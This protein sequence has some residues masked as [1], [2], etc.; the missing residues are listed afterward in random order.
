MSKRK[1][2]HDLITQQEAEA[3]THST[4][5]REEND[6]DEIVEEQCHVTFIDF[7]DGLKAF[8]MEAKLCYG[9]Y[10]KLSPCNVASICFLI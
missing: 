8:D 1:K 5:S 2:L 9:V 7:P 4:I 3:I 6:E 10:T